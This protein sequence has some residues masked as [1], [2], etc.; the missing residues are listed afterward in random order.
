MWSQSST[1]ARTQRHRLA[2]AVA[3]APARGRSPHHKLAVMVPVAV[4]LRMTPRSRERALGTCWTYLA[5]VACHQ[6]SF[7]SATESLLAHKRTTASWGVHATKWLYLHRSELTVLCHAAAEM[8]EDKPL[9][10][11]ADK[12][13]GLQIN[14]EFRRSGGSVVLDLTLNHKGA[15]GSADFSNLHVQFNKNACGL[16]PVQTQVPVESIAPGQRRVCEVRLNALADFVPAPGKPVES[17]VQ[18][19]LKFHGGNNTVQYLRVP[20]SLA[21]LCVE[22]GR[23]DKAMYL[24]T[25]R[26]IPNE[27]E[28]S[29]KI[30][31]ICERCQ[32]SDNIIDLLESCN[33]FNTARRQDQHGTM[34]LELLYASLQTVNGV[35]VLIELKLPKGGGNVCK[36]AVRTG[37]PP[38]IPLVVS[39]VERLLQTGQTSERL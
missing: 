25:W 28:F 26:S 3:P 34:L 2:V 11:G 20:F 5:P 36:V 24:Q 39:F 27:A 9:V 31:G 17:N 37:D 6:V 19:A 7:P 4:K 33:I 32:V 13:G 10:L 35:N 18:C 22:D 38:I 15:G 12:T 23:M 14:A 21:T 8:V 29:R 1:M 30:E 16:K